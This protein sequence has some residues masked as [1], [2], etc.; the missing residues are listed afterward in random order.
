MCQRYLPHLCTHFLFWANRGGKKCSKTKKSHMKKNG[1]T[2]YC[3]RARATTYS[4]WTRQSKQDNSPTRIEA[5]LWYQT[6]KSPSLFFCMFWP[7]LPPTREP[8]S[9]LILPL[10]IPQRHYYSTIIPNTG[11]ITILLLRAHPTF[12]YC[13]H[14]NS[15]HIHFMPTEPRNKR[16][17]LQGNSPSTLPQ[18]LILQPPAPV[19][20]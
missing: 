9:P 2:H 1:D 10:F 17:S 12:Y 16:P 13:K 7:A 18:T 5:F 3:C 15:I 19:T 6:I 14:V 4:T 11:E 8:P 20:L